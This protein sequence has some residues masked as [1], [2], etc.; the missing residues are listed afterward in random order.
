LSDSERFESLN[1]QKI[2]TLPYIG[3]TPPDDH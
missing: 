1:V 2:V 3:N